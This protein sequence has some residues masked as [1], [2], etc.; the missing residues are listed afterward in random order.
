MNIEEQIASKV[1]MQAAHSQLLTLSG[2]VRPGR[3]RVLVDQ[4]T[5][6]VCI[7]IT[8]LRN[9]AHPTEYRLARSVEDAKSITCPNCGT[10]F[11]SMACVKTKCPKCRAVV[12]FEK[13]RWKVVG[14]TK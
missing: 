9:V 8:G 2:L 4:I 13:G 5:R 14:G 11:D 10:E 6:N 3:E 1:A 12:R 7:A